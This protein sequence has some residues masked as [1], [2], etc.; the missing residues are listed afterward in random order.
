MVFSMANLK[1]Q[2]L[3]SEW[4]EETEDVRRRVKELMRENR[5]DVTLL[6]EIER[7][8]NPT[9]EDIY[10]QFYKDKEEE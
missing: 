9:I 5:L 3:E 4:M 7:K 2:I 1:I 8:H 10:N 6:E